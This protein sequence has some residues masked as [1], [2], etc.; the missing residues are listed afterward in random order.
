MQLMLDT[1]IQAE[2]GTLLKFVCTVSHRPTEILLIPSIGAQKLGKGKTFFIIFAD[3][4]R[5]L[6]LLL[7]E[8]VLVAVGNSIRNFDCLFVA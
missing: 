6:I 2:H 4:S 1:K 5:H 3:N 8:V 7:P